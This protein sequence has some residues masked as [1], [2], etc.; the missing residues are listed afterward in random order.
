M[1]TI[2]KW[3]RV[4]EYCLLFL[5][6]KKSLEFRVLNLGFSLAILWTSLLA[7]FQFISQS[8]IGGFWYWLGERTFNI[9]TPSIAKFSI[10]GHE[11][12]RAYS[13]FPH[14]NA[15]A[16]FLLVG[17]LLII[18][19]ETKN[20]ENPRS[21]TAFRMTSKLAL[22]IALLTIPLTFSRTAIFLEILLIIYL[23][24]PKFKKVL[25]ILSLLTLTTY[26]TT[27]YSQLSTSLTDRMWLIEKS[28]IAIQKSPIMGLGLGSFPVFQPHLSSPSFALQFQPVHN[29]FLLLISELGLPFSLFITFNVVKKAIRLST[30]HLALRAAILVIA[31]TGMV[32]HYWLTIH[33]NT[34]LLVLLLA[35]LK[36]KLTADD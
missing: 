15:L 35:L 23:F 34:L 20:P 28:V 32:D 14:P 30:S 18:L 27:H 11:Y 4:L 10:L 13:T 31:I 36:S 21:F 17:A 29:I 19:S 2:Y 16:G 12:L 6:L 8:S 3:L 5:S 22:T 9:V 24:I 25:I 33:Q 26:L 7:W 1:V